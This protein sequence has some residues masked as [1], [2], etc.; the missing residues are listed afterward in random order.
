MRVLVT[1]AGG[2]VGAR[3]AADLSM[4]GHDVTGTWHLNRDRLPRVTPANLCFVQIDLAEP[5]VVDSMFADAGNFDAV[6]HTAAVVASAGEDPDFLAQAAR[7]NVAGMANLVAAACRT[8]CNRF[9]FTSTIS[10]YDNL[11]APPG[12]YREAESSPSTWY[13]WSK[14]AGE[15]LLEAAAQK[16]GLTAISLRLAGVHGE[17]RTSG[18]LHAMAGAAL[19]GQALVVNEPESRFRWAWIDDVSAAASRACEA[20]W[21]GEAAVFNLASADIFTLKHLAERLIAL[22]NAGGHVDC[23]GASGLV[24]DEFMNIDEVVRRLAFKPA[25]LDEFLS[26]YLSRRQA[27]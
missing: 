20:D 27:T 5:E 1:G 4:A 11:G 26:R 23:S 22:A 9:V 16:T 17:G 24:R 2:F 19:E 15:G 18:A 12:G 3:I 14:R 6:V 21:P 25:G 8:Q 10:V 13:G 7:A